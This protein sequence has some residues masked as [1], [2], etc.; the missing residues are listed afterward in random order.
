MSVE[1]EA[2]QKRFREGLAWMEDRCRAETKKGLAEAS[3]DQ[4]IALLTPLSDT[5]ATVPS[6]LKTGASFFTELKTR[7]IFGFYTS[8]EGFVEDL[9]RPEH[10]GMEKW[11]GCPH[12]EGTH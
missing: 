8:R 10:I 6:E 1:P 4:L 9:G 12:P 3:A 2:I 7:T 11:I 5:N